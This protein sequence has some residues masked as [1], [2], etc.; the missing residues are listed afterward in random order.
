MPPALVSL[1]SSRLINAYGLLVCIVA[2]A[3]ALYLQHYQG[4]DPCPLCIFQRIAVIAAGLFFLIGL[5]FN[6]AGLWRRLWALLALAGSA[7]GIGLAVRHIWLQG[8]PPEQV[9]ACGPGL[10]YMFDVFP[11][12]EM[13]DMVLNGSGECAE[14]DWTL[15]GITL[16]QLALATFAALAALALVQLLRPQPAR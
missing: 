12:M 11:F 10:G 9:P 5:V 1:T 15:W 4:L 6:P 2:M 14:I 8:L 3:A 7:S 16:P 13:L